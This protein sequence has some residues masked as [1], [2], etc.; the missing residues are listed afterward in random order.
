MHGGVDRPTLQQVFQGA[1]IDLS[2]QPAVVARAVRSIR[3]CRTARLGGHVAHCEP[4]GHTHYAY[5]SCRNRHCPQCQG[6]AA[7]A[8]VRH[9]EATLLGVRYY[10]VVFSLPHALNRLIA[11]NREDL[12]G[13][14][15]AH[16]WATLQHFAHRYLD[17]GKLGV[18]MVLHTWGQTLNRHVHVHALVTAGALTRAGRWRAARGNYLF[19]VR[20]VR[21]WFRRGFLDALKERRETLR[22]PGDLGAWSTCQGFNDGLSPLYRTTWTVYFKP[23]FG[24]PRH[25]LRYLARYTHRV[26]ISDARLERLDE[27]G[28]RFRYRDYRVDKIQRMTL[29]VA[30][31]VTRFLW[32]VLPHRFVR[33]RHYGLNA[34]N[35]RPDRER[36]CAAIG[37]A[38]PKVDAPESLDAY[39]RRVF[40]RPLTT[41]PKCLRPGSLVL[42]WF[43]PRSRDPPLASD[44]AT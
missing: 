23:P 28:V 17:G 39:F 29:P 16:A 7:E 36:A 33:I 22:F 25:L 2:R 8:W 20:A 30:Q 11:A 5:H 38:V 14:L 10:H 44:H 42:L 15:F 31:F 27:E 18:T 37:C 40:R 9:R 6:R 21:R 32:H 13:L 41:C 43:R 24:G 12:F 19:P 35:A 34:N 26:A 3:H 1:A 4:C